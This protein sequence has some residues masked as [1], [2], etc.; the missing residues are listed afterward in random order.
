MP[1][2]SYTAAIDQVNRVLYSIGK[3]S[4]YPLMKYSIDNDS[5]STVANLGKGG[6]RLDYNTVDGLL[7]F[8]TSDKLYSYDPLTGVLLSTWDI[9]G[10]DNLG[11]GDLAFDDTGV[12]YMCTF[13]GL[14]ELTLDAN[15]DYQADRKSADT[16][17]F[18][19]TSM[20]FDSNHELWLASNGSSSN[21]IIMDTQT[22]DG[23]IIMDL[24][25]IIIQI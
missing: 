7:Y 24:V 3:S 14:Y 12:L 6:P 23:S 13:S 2:G 1:M 19:P 16:L 4:P 25:L 8:S 18:N 22:E 20:T 15:G 21:L 10:L 17:P 9:I 11:G 5:W